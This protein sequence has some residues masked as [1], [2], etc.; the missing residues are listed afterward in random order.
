M[1]KFAGNR[2]ERRRQQREWLRDQGLLPVSHRNAPPPGS[3]DMPLSATQAPS[4]SMPQPDP[5][6][7]RLVRLVEFLEHPWLLWALALVA[8]AVGLVL[9]TP[10]FVVMALCFAGAFHRKKV[11]VGLP[12]QVQ[13]LS[14]IGVLGIA[15]FLAW[16]GVKAARTASQDLARLI[17]AD[18]KAMTTPKPAP[19][20]PNYPTPNNPLVRMEGNAVPPSMAMCQGMPDA[21]QTAC[22]CPSPLDYSLKALPTPSDNNYSTEIDIRKVE[23]P[24]YRLRI[25]SRTILGSTGPIQVIPPLSHSSAF[26]GKMDYDP[27]SFIMSST[28]P[29]DEFKLEVHTSEGLRLKCINQDN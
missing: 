15:F 9:Y 20:D 8:A 14:Y 12:W 19:P 29:E 28:A 7:N 13:A 11:V 24:I 1:P 25:F 26:L 22:L 10:A 16:I 4:S 17:V 27:Y 21:A 18:F 3:P 23:R 5:S 2:M 6:P